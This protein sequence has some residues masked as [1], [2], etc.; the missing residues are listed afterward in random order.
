MT[1]LVIASAASFETKR[2]VEQLRSKGVSLTWIE[3][4]VGLTTTT[5]VCSSLRSLVADRHVVFCGTGGIVKSFNEHSTLFTEPQIHLVDRVGLA[6]FDVRSNQAYLLADFDVSFS[7][8]NS[9]PFNAQKCEAVGSLGITKSHEAV[10]DSNTSLPKLE[11]IELYGVTKCWSEVSK[12]FSA[13][14][15]STNF[16]GPQAHAQWQKNF[17]LAATMTADFLLTELERLS[18][19]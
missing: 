3:T 17:N 12:S 14:L 18:I 11:T 1:R 10:S 8:K 15:A 2:L 4:G 19:I 13:I 9:L 5:A 16:T 6:P 7:L